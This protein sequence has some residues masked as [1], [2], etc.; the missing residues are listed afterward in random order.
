MKRTICRDFL[1]VLVTLL[2]IQ[3]C[4]PYA[5]EPCEHHAE[6]DRPPCTG[7]E[8]ET[9]ACVNHCRDGYPIDFNTDKHFG[10]TAYRLDETNE[11]LLILA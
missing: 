6:G 1:R 3:G 2:N 4:Q 11:H 10:S 9:P 8:G 7:E 5:I